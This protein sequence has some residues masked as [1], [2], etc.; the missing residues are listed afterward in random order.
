MF[1]LVGMLE[2]YYVHLEFQA[3]VGNWSVNLPFLCDMC[4]V[5]CTLDDFLTAGEL[6]G[7]AEVD[8]EVYAKFNVLKEELGELFERGEDEYDKY[9]TSTKC[10]FQAGNI[11]SIYAIRPD[12]CRQFPNTPFG[13]LSEDCKA[14]DRFK[15]QCLALKRGCV[16]K[17]T[18]HFT[19][20]SIV[21]AI[22]SEKQRLACLDKLCSAGITEQ[23]IAFFKLLN[24][25]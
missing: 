14:L 6:Q 18:G 22:F 7:S 2:T 15:K 11:C 20:D 1:W 16:V 5:C 13:M 8:C 24:K 4:G 10:P 25:L 3:K 21:P 12:G 19:T 9:V 23:E 17:E